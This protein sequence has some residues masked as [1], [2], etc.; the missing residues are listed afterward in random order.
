MQY[1]NVE[2]NTAPLYIF[3]LYIIQCIIP[4]YSNFV[5]ETTQTTPTT[6]HD[7][8][9]M[10]SALLEDMVFSESL[11]YLSTYIQAKQVV[12]NSVV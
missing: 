1:W 8:N 2:S 10:N 5:K 3:S 6:D 7:A 9:R 12:E 11:T 4:Q